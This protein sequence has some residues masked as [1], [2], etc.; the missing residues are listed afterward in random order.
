VSEVRIGHGG[1]WQLNGHSATPAAL[2]FTGDGYV[3][4]QG[5]LL[6]LSNP[7]TNQLRVIRKAPSKLGWF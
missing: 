6:Q 5:G 3:D 1:S 7:N 4:S 2:T